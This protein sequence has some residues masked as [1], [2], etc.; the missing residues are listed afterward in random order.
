MMYVYSLM[1]ILD[2]AA[3]IMSHMGEMH[4]YRR[5][6]LGLATVR[7]QQVVHHISM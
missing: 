3:H 5:L 7:C 4:I 2:I 1:K 6:A